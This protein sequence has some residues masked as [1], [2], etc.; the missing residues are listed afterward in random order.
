MRSLPIPR[1]ECWVRRDRTA[2]GDACDPR[3]C[4]EAMAPVPGSRH[5]V[6]CGESTP[7]GSADPVRLPI[8][9]D[10][11]TTCDTLVLN[12]KRSQIALADLPAP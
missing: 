9:I 1:L 8:S 2:H 4:E 6:L 7:L 10:P 5:L 11:T 12:D 3:I